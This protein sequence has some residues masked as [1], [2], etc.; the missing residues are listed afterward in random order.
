MLSDRVLL[1][2]KGEDGERKTRTGLLIPATAAAS[3]RKCIWGEVVATGPHVRQVESG[4]HVL[5]LPET[6]Y[7]V[8][9]R[10][11]EFLLVREREIHAV[12]AERVEPQGTGLY[13]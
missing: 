13:L 3:I 9:I 7:E 6:G 2:L 11:E 10:D 4:D 8:E 5:I 12:A 1:K